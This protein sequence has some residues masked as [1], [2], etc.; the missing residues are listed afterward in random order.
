MAKV[1]VS[2]KEI[3][4]RLRAKRERRGDLAR[5]PIEKKIEILV[6]LQRMASEVGASAG[7]KAQRPWRAD[8]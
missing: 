2:R 7:R 6:R 8:R 3:E 5:L 1:T 4:R